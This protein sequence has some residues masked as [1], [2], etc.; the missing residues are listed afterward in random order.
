MVCPKLIISCLPP[1]K[2]NN[3]KRFIIQ[4]KDHRVRLSQ[5]KN[6]MLRC[7]MVLDKKIT[8]FNQNVQYSNCCDVVTFDSIIAT[9]LKLLSNWFFTVRYSIHR[10]QMCQHNHDHSHTVSTVKFFFLL[11]F[12]VCVCVCGYRTITGS[13]LFQ[14]NQFVKH[15]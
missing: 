5:N 1:K 13:K 12:S 3:N 2:N 8:G 15:V 14:R 9:D 7:A 4:S 10:N 6:S 11:S